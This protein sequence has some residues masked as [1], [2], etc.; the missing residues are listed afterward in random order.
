MA[1][2]VVIS[3]LR[4]VGICNAQT[5][6]IGRIKMMKSETMLTAQSVRKKR[7]LLIQWPS[8]SGSHN[9][10]RGMHIAALAPMLAK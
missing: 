6:G 10:G 1:K 3:I 9:L 8:S 5:R 2:T 7:V 4:L